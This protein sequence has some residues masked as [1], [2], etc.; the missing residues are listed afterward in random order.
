MADPTRSGV[1]TDFDG[2]LAPIVDD[3]DRARPLPGTSEVLKALAGRFATVAVVS[4]RP[5]AY[6]ADHLPDAGETVLI[7]LYGLERGHGRPLVIEEAPAARAWR[8]AVDA[9][10]GAAEATAPAPLL[11]ERKGLAVTL[12]YRQAPAL[13][14]WAGDFAAA[15]AAATGLVAHPGKMSVE[16][17]PPVETDK[18][19][20]VDEL[21]SGLGAACFFGDDLGDL[22]TFA[23]LDRLRA[24]GVTTLAVAVSGAETPADLIAAADLVV[25]GPPGALEL[26]RTLADQP[27]PAAAR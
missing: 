20:V 3:P 6:L 27:P 15:Q 17:R 19:T 10:A 1:F 14:R 2:T 9:A 12:H 25:D 23:A 22:P 21:A 11:V 5:L 26:L 7:G 24:A 18:G 13:A 16:L 8:A 4:G